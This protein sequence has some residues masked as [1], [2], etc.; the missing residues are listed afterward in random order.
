MKQSLKAPATVREL[1][2][3]AEA[4]GMTVPELL[5]LLGP[6]PMPPAGFILAAKSSDRWTGPEI[7][8]RG[9]IVTPVWNATTGRHSLEVWISD[10]VP[11][12]YGNLSP[13]DALQLAADLTAAA[14]E[15]A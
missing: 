5:D 13:A 2:D 6:I 3:M 9:W 12:A 1:G 15:A 8:R 4:L 10:H 14:G 11:P 7:V